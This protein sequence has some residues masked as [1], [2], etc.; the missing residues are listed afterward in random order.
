MNTGIRRMGDL[1]IKE[2][3]RKLKSLAVK[4]GL[5]KLRS[6]AASKMPAPKKTDILILTAFFG[7]GHHNVSK[8]IKE[9]LLA[10]DQSLSI[11]IR[12]LFSVTNPLLEQYAYDLYE[13]I[14]KEMP[15]L[16]NYFYRKRKDCTE[17]YIDEIT[18]IM[19]LQRLTEYIL[20]T[21]PRLIISTFPLC[22]NIVSRFKKKQKSSMPLATCITDVVDSYEWLSD[23]TDLYLLPADCIKNSLIKKGISES[24]LKVTGIP[25]RKSFLDSENIKKPSP[26]EVKRVTVMG[27]GRGHFDIEMEL[28]RTLD[29]MS[30]VETSII[31]GKNRELFETL[32]NQGFQN[33]RIIGYVKD[34]AFLMRRTT[35]LV[36]KPGGVTLFEAINC[37]TPLIAKMPNIGQEMENANFIKKYAL[38]AVKNTTLEVAGE[39]ERLLGDHDELTKLQDNIKSF[40]ATLERDKIGEHLMS[41]L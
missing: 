41:L 37:E 5:G 25:V 34:P 4:N 24:R 21:Q 9:Q 29:Q 19:G 30:G 2:E 1:D 33:T 27:G 3:V 15:E 26:G 20:E 10:L 39:I 17:Y 13:L 7:S 6:P 36:T 35:L 22:S 12:D 23:E 16:Y 18:S 38:G 28:L 8:A 32:H 11:E 14:T 31:T 40:K